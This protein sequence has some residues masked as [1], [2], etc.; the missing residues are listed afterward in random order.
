MNDLTG[1]LAFVTGSS[2]GIGRATGLK[3]AQ[4]GAKV[5]FHGTQP[6]E[7][8]LSAVAEAENNAEYLTADFGNMDEVIALADTLKARALVP[9]ILVLN[10]SVQSYTGLGNFDNA[11][12]LRMFTTN[13]QSSCILLHELL[14]EMRKKNGGRVIFVGSINGIQPASRLAIYG[15]TKAALMNIA[16]TAALENAPYGLT[17]NTI[18]P[19][20]IETDRN[21]KALSDQAFAD[22]LKEQIPMHRFGT[23]EECAELIAFLASDAAAYITGAEIPIAGGWQL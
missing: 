18:L 10:A 4:L 8:L 23:S 15:S 16:Q 22:K 11:E 13:V 6:G 9:D 7:K 2:R 5:I 14:P 20:V 17:V 3:L 12:F 21:A 1:K 19:G